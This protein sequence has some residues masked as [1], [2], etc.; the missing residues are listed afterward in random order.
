MT[1]RFRSVLVASIFVLGVCA[2]IPVGIQQMGIETIARGAPTAGATERG[3]RVER[4]RWKDHMEIHLW[5]GAQRS[6]TIAL[7]GIQLQA[8]HRADWV[9][10]DRA[11][12]FE[13]DVHD[14]K[15][16]VSASHQALLYDFKTGTIYA[17]GNATDWLIGSRGTGNS[18]HLSRA[19]FDQLVATL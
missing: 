10:K 17:A 2:L 5:E 12:M 8:L 7:D 18:Q 11:V 6:Y 14:P 1:A 15:S 3:F 16:R 19:E 9:A 4:S 13:M